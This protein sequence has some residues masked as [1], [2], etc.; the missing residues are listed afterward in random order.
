L[1][2]LVAPDVARLPDH[3]YLSGTVLSPVV[4]AKRRTFLPVDFLNDPHGERMRHEIP[5]RR[6]VVVVLDGLR[7]DAIERFGLEHMQTLMARGASSRRA[8]TVA[9]SVT[10]AAMTSLMTGVGP[11]THGVASDRLFIPKPR[12]GLVA[13][14]DWLAQHGFPSSAFMAEVPVVFR[15]IA[16]R[17]GRRLGLSGLHLA[18]SDA[19]GILSAARSTLRSQR[20]GL[21]VLHWPDADRAGHA[22]GWMSPEYADGCR[23][24]DA[25][26]GAVMSTCND[27]GTVVVALADHGGGGKQPNDHESDHPLDRTI[28]IGFSGAAI[29]RR[30]LGPVTL[31]DVPA[32]IVHALGLSIP[33]SFEGSV[34]HEVFA[35]SDEPASA[36][37]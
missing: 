35:G 15:G 18:G 12:P 14:P 1:I 20:R 33:S 17:I 29:A 3:R 34:L 4:D 36:V 32:T 6:V 37:A 5:V 25:S 19:A 26:L 28:P 11:A 8:T 31:L 24:L 30:E 13:L 10:T 7:P 2:D 27:A 23:R 9:P 21:I 16:V 22:H